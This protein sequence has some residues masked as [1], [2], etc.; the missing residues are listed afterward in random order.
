MLGMEKLTERKGIIIDVKRKL[1]TVQRGFYRRNK[2]LGSNSHLAIRD[3]M[4]K[5]IIV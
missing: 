1:R 4:K 2:N 3:V 5:P